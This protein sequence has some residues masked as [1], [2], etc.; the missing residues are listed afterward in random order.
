[1]TYQ[2]PELRATRKP[3]AAW[4]RAHLWDGCQ[5]CDVNPGVLTSR[6]EKIKQATRAHGL[7]PGFSAWNPPLLFTTIH[8]RQWLRDHG[9]DPSRPLGECDHIVPLWEKGGTDDE[10][11]R[12]LLCVPC[13]KVKSAE[14]ARRRAKAPKHRTPIAHYGTQAI[15]DMREKASKLGIHVDPSHT[16]G[17]ED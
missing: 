12:Q 10:D 8:A 5:H 9:F 4:A 13:H 6:F 2:D 11:N 15:D 14:E 16:G 17:E 3:R 7:R 1:M